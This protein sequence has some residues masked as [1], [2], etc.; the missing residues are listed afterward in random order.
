LSAQSSKISIFLS[1][2]HVFAHYIHLS[3]RDRGEMFSCE[4]TRMTA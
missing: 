4:K 2:T 1:T 3:L